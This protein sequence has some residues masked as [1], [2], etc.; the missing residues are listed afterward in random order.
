M[1]I[2]DVDTLKVKKFQDVKVIA[3]Y[4]VGTFGDR[5]ISGHKSAWVKIHAL[6][7]AP[8]QYAP[9]FLLSNDPK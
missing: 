2:A 1:L 6:V 3:L 8:G 4:N 9:S 7:A 5:G